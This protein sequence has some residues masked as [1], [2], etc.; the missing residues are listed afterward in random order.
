[1]KIIMCMRVHF[2]MH[3]YMCVFAYKYELNACMSLE[4]ICVYA[5]TYM[6]F[7]FLVMYCAFVCTVK[8]KV[9]RESHVHI[10]VFVYLCM[11]VQ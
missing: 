9:L 8:T 5:G 4:Y 2:S 11:C 7:P 3:L 6:C 1:M 10:P